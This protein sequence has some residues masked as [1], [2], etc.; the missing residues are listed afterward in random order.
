MKAPIFIGALLLAAAAG[1]VISRYGASH[2]RIEQAAAPGASVD[3]RPVL[4]P[5]GVVLDYR[6]GTM[7]IDGTI[8]LP[9]GATAPDTLWAWAYFINPNVSNGSW[10]DEPIPVANPFTR[11][12]TAR[13]SARGHF[14]WWN[15]SHLGQ[16]D[17]FLAHV[18]VSTKS[19]DDARVRV[20][21]RDFS[22]RNMIPV[23][24]RYADSR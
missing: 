3:D 22:L 7:L 16:R 2:G 8:V 14:H 4:F 24:S 1:S 5:Q 9:R 13:F 15:N 12:D 10:S 20:G 19:A 6:D 23:H 18:T 17:G 21:E 11:G